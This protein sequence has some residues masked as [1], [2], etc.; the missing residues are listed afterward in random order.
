MVADVKNAGLTAEDKPEF[1][2]LRRNLPEEWT[3]DSTMVLKT[4]LS[5]AAAALWMRSQIAQSIRPFRSRS[6]P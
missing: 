2:R 1:Y 5:P 6:K 3:A 4:S